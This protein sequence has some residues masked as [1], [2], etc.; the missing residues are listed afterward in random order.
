MIESNESEV[1]DKIFALNETN[2]TEFVHEYNALFGMAYASSEYMCLNGCDSCYDGVCAILDTMEKTL[3]DYSEPNFTA[4]DFIYGAN[5]LSPFI[6][7]FTYTYTECAHYTSGTTLDGK[8]CYGVNADTSLI[9]SINTP[10]ILEYDDTACNSCFFPGENESE[11]YIADCTNIDA[12]AM[13][14]SCNGTGFVGPFVF[15]GLL[16]VKNITSISVTVGTCNELSVPS[17]PTAPGTT[18]TSG[19]VTAT[20]PM[21]P[22]SMD[23]PVSVPIAPTSATSPV[24]APIQTPTVTMPTAPLT[25]GSSVLGVSVNVLVFGSGAIATYFS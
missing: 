22:T 19:D 11:C 16:E 21:A 20:A 1:Q 25:S 15:L 9:A 23:A 4:N 3:M 8:L 7:N 2:I 10:C 12:S 5:D 24:K 13:I 18:P 17:S 6:T 14:D